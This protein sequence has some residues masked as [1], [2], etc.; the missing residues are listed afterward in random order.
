MQTNVLLAWQA[1]EDELAAAQ[2]ELPDCE[3]TTLPIHQT[4][5]RYEADPAVLREAIPDADVI[6][7]WSMPNDVLR[8]CDRARLLTWLHSGVDPID[9][10]VLEDQEIALTNVAGANAVAVA[11][12]AFALS[13]ALIKRLRERGDNVRA[14]RWNPLWDPATSSTLLDGGTLITIG[15]GAIAKRVAHIGRAFGMRCVA[16]NRSGSAEGFDQVVDHTGLLEALSQ[17]DLVILAVPFTEETDR[18]FGEA[19]FAALPST[20]FVVNV[21]RG[22]VV[23]EVSLRRALDSDE[24]A[25]FATDVWWWYPNSMPE[26]WHYAVPSRLGLH[27]HPKV[28]ATGDHACDILAIRDR[29]YAQGLENARA[30]LAGETPPNILF[31]GTTWVRRP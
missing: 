24:I 28:I 7:A 13:L 6:V 15:A 3:V 27:Q 18:M 25:G 14:G 29:M 20:A 11:E 31:D 5:S 4:L 1:S 23:D 10:S 21:C 19:E 9:Q 16:L 2:A 22:R 26:G 17:A 8:E 30:F 12:H